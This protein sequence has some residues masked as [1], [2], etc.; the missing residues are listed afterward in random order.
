MDISTMKNV[1]T[2]IGGRSVLKLRKYSPQILTGVGIAGGI[3]SAVMAS[4]ATLHLEERMDKMKDHLETIKL[5][6]TE[7]LL[8]HQQ[9][10]RE[11]ALI[12]TSAVLSIGR[13]YAPAASVGLLSIA[14][15]ISAQGIMQ[16]R[17]A[18]LVA[19]YAA[20]DKS[21]KE[22]RK[23]VEAQL[24]EEGERKIR[25]DVEEIEEHDTEE[26]VVRKVAKHNAISPYAKFFDEYN[27]NW[28]KNADYN[29][30][31]LRSQ[32][33][34]ANDMLHA[35]GHVFLNE[36]Y[37]MLGMDRTKAGAT[38][39]WVRGNGDDCIDFGIYRDSDNEALRAFVNGQERSI[40]LDFNVDGVIL[41]LI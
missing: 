26:G 32:Q 30:M 41:D 4:M 21:F 22:Y 17:N 29:L 24:G 25:Y 35:R 1:A 23:R 19:A 13:L 16:K 40:L 14:C 33:M 8:D 38:V 11:S 39:G 37:D 20:V 9:F 3:T 10:Q 15:I 7:G 5:G 36:V 18:S 31:F 28:A 12:Y 34:S 27:P 2:R 6:R